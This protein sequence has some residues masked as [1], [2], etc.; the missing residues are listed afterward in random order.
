MRVIVTGGAGF[1]GSS[2][3][4]YLMDNYEIEVVCVDK[5]TYCANKNN[6]K[7]K[8]EFIEKDICDI[9]QDDLGSY[10]YLVNFAAESHV[11]NSISNGMPF[12]KSNIEGVFNLLE[13]AR[14]NSNLIKFIQISTDEVYGDM[15]DYGANVEADETFSLKASSYYS[16]SKAA[17]DLL[18]QSCNRTFGLP[19]LI[20]RTCNNFGEH[21][22]PE[23]FLP[24]IY[25]S[26]QDGKEIPLYG[27]GEHVREWIHV[28]DNARY[29]ALLMFSDIKNEVVNIGSGIK[30]SNNRIINIIYEKVRGKWI[31]IKSVPDR[32]GHDKRY[33]LNSNKLKDILKKIKQSSHV[34]HI[35]DYFENLYGEKN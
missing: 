32:L 3:I 29:I 16:A 9:T 24:K 34:K 7:H 19:Y 27:N 23:K 6:I 35:L 11:D 33:S 30:Y 4:N 8:V 10:D 28:D 31:K 2:F 12:I 13:V 14:K 26:I 15:F 21:Q 17:A 22:H 20:T 1:I 18:V 5:M 25:Q